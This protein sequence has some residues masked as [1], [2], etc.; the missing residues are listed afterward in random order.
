LEKS[1]EFGGAHYL[2]RSQTGLYNSQRVRGTLSKQR[3]SIPKESTVRT[4][5]VFSCARLSFELVFGW[6]RRKP[7]WPRHVGPVRGVQLKH[8]YH[9]QQIPVKLLRR[10][11]QDAAGK[12]GK[13]RC[14]H[15]DTVQT[16]KELEK[17]RCFD[18][19]NDHKASSVRKSAWTMSAYLHTKLRLFNVDQS[20]MVYKLQSG[21]RI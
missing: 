14:F 9:K 18:I 5:Q 2:T 10:V 3:A 20:H 16:R 12:E 6:L 15:R 13:V 17:A 21:I 4:G 8:L 1:I 11:I 19:K 7:F